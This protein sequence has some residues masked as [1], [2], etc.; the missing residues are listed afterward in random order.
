MHVEQF[1]RA[2]V[3]IVSSLPRRTLLGGI[4]GLVV[5][6]STRQ[7]SA[8]RRRKKKKCKGR[9]S[10]CGKKC[11]NLNT[12]SANCGACGVA[13]AEGKVCSN[14]NC[15][16][17]ADQSLVAGACIP[18]FGC[19]LQLD[20]CEFGKQAC[21][22]ATNESDARCYVSANGEPFCARSLE[23]AAV[24]TGGACPTIGGKARVVIPCSVCT[25]PGETDGCV[26]PIV[27]PRAGV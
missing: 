13:C 12:D 9:T 4:L 8:G 6:E 14:G 19:T 11:F 16:C 5:A 2:L 15:A 21:P 10:R 17:P 25:V 18:R 20:T 24:P 27:R 26:L 3:I 23:C 22:V 1:D 7:P